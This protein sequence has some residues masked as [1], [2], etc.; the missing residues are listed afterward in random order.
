MKILYIGDYRCDEVK[1]RNEIKS[2]I[3]SN[4]RNTLIDKIVILW[5]KWNEYKDLE[6][7]NYLFDP[8]IDIFNWDSRQTYLDFYNNSLE[9]YPNDIIIISNSD[10]V[11][12][13]TINRITE[14]NFTSRLVYAL[15]RYD[16]VILNDKLNKSIRCLPFPYQSKINE[17]WSFDTYI[18][19]H[20]LEIIPETI[21]IQIGIG[22]C[23]SYLVKKLIVDNLIEVVNPM[24]DIRC[25]HQDYRIYEN[26]QKPYQLLFN[27]NQKN[28]YPGYNR[29]YNIGI[30]HFDSKKGI[31]LV[32]LG[33]SDKYILKNLPII[34]HPLK[35]ISFSLYGNNEKYTLGAIKNAEVAL[36]IY[37]EWK[38]WFYVH[39]ESV[40]KNI[41][42]RL[43]EFPNVEIIFKHDLIL[44]TTW[45][46]LPLEL[47]YVSLFISRDCDSLISERERSCVYE[48]INSSK[49]FHI[50]RDHPNH[51]GIKTHR[52][53]AGMIGFKRMPYF[54]CWNTIM[55]NYIKY[56]N[57]WGIDQDII[58]ENIYPL[59]SK[60]CDIYVS[61]TFNKFESFCKEI[62]VKYNEKI[63]FIGEY[64]SENE[65]GRVS[66]HIN[67]I[68][69]GLK[70][71]NNCIAKPLYLDKVIINIFEE[72]IDNKV[73]KNAYINLGIDVIFN[74]IPL[75]EDIPKEYIK[76]IMNIL[77]W[78]LYPDIN[79]GIMICP[80]NLI[81]IKKQFYKNIV[82]RFDNDRLIIYKKIDNYFQ[83]Y[84]NIAT[85]NVWKDI[86]IFNNIILNSIDDIINFSKKLY[87]DN[88]DIDELFF[89]YVMNYQKK[90]GLIIILDDDYTNYKTG[91][92]INNIDMVDI[93]I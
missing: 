2:V 48:W 19:K 30:Q 38:C 53:M 32:P 84:Y 23:D 24:L 92:Y 74:I 61:A 70:N 76:K 11:F 46:F 41:I 22:G 59:A 44:P 88:T 71:E 36:D 10:I 64:W 17:N 40:P 26:I 50:I 90:T 3:N 51:G 8:K 47:E 58:Q 75:I 72:N 62:P 12:D 39:E 43:K 16:I 6:E 29:T 9:Y 34:M 87:K 13:N 14:Y 42:D 4:K 49:R 69:E 66:T 77:V 79:G 5:E 89:N 85:Y 37:P 31:E 80:D 86:F 91:D 52:I 20:P 54:K 93:K 60:Y 21:D 7:Y 27:Y 83:N 35:V 82:Q 65:E 67:M 45:R 18:F 1:R 81:P 25:W 56:N 28:D 33:E 15:T 68:T 78:V 63:N 57:N 73:I 55:P